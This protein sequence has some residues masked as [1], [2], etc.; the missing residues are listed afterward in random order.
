[1]K[2]HNMF[3]VLVTTVSITILALAAWPARG[4][5]VKEIAKLDSFSEHLR[6][7]GGMVWSRKPGQPWDNPQEATVG[8]AVKKLGELYPDA[9]FAVDPQVA[10]VAVTDLV[11]RSQDP[12]IDLQALAAACG[13]KFDF[14]QNGTPTL[15]I[16][17]PNNRTFS[18]APSKTEDR[19]LECFNL[20]GYLLPMIAQDNSAPSGAVAGPVSS[21]S[22]TQKAVAQLQEIIQKSIT[23]L[24]PSMKQPHFK[25]YS[26]GQLLV[27]IGPQ[28]ALEVAEI[29]IRA[30]PG[31]QAPPANHAEGA[32]LNDYKRAMRDFQ[33]DFREAQ[34][35]M[36]S[37]KAAEADS[38]ASKP[39]P[40]PVPEN[41][42]ANK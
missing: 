9:T 28:Q 42:P 20:T 33:K 21:E 41:N 19:S 38:N 22:H 26:E 10:V 2:T 12:K 5:N 15:F 24:D 30:L 37:L 3:G 16:L 11:V 25:F 35:Y 31:Q 18:R 8:N 13:G 27:V 14:R 36:K 40:A 1:M 32:D 29:I 34:M 17:E 6:V 39:P 23:D 4:Q 7:E